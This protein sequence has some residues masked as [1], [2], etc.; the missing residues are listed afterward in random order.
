MKTVVVLSGK[1]GT[2]KTS[3]TASLA[4]L[5][6]QGGRRIVLADTDVDASNLHLLLQPS[7]E[8][9]HQYVGGQVAEV[10]LERCLGHGECAAHCRFH[11]I[12]LARISHTLP[13]VAA[14]APAGTTFLA[15]APPTTCLEHANA[16]AGP[17]GASDLSVRPPCGRCARSLATSWSKAHTDRHLPGLATEVREK[18]GLEDDDGAIKA[19]I[20]P[21]LCEGCAVCTV[22]CP[23]G[24]INMHDQ[25]AGTWRRGNTR[26]GP[27]VDAR[28]SPG[29]ENSGKLVTRVRQAALVEAERI[30]ADLLLMDG[31][32]GVGCPVIAAVTG[33][34]MVVAVTEPTP[35]ALSDLER[36]VSLARHFNVPVAVVINKADLNPHRAEAFERRLTAS[37][38][39]VL[40]RIP[41][42][43]A[44]PQALQKGIL[45]VDAGGG[46]ARAFAE[47]H[48][49]F[50]Q[51]L[52][53]LSGPP[54]PTLLQIESLGL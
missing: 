17:C 32:P 25:V 7:A 30:G 40:G 8:E 6:V 33:T 1:G 54:Q 38:I 31:P 39:E 52:A 34:D 19:H 29:G 11:A 36:L 18:Y 12:A 45:P 16:H 22:V 23:E 35:P 15:A 21:T 14:D 27:L 28:L 37:A 9:E 13:A 47:V 20:D 3:V 51:R 26:L 4:D 5:E 46:F 24:A 48:Q 41:Y 43:E 53:A 42:D 50:R 2:G 10:I 44:V 49:R